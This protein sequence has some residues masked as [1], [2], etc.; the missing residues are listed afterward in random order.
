MLGRRPACG[1]VLVML[2]VRIHPYEACCARRWRQ[3][4]VKR[5]IQCVLTQ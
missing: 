5:R 4:A 1:A 2:A 3:N